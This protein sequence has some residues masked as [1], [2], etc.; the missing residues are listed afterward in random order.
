MY[1]L[2]TRISNLV[3]RCTNTW[4][5]AAGRRWLGAECIV[6]RSAHASVWTAQAT[7]GQRKVCWENERRQAM[8]GRQLLVVISSDDRRKRP[9]GPTSRRLPVLPPIPADGSPPQRSAA[10]WVLSG[11]QPS[12][13][14]LC[15]LRRS[16]SSHV[17]VR[18][19][20]LWLQLR[21]TLKRLGSRLAT[22]NSQQ[23]ATLNR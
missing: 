7:C 1:T 3:S 9:H 12:R 11:M 21:A 17:I 16:S 8:P 2:S 5:W 14:F 18:T 22:D 15:R 19:V 10:V 6:R 13:C 4:Q 23:E 20:R